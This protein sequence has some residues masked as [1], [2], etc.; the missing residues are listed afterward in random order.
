MKL[1]SDKNIYSF[2]YPDSVNIG[3]EI[4]TLAAIHVLKLLGLN[5]S[6]Y[7]NRDHPILEKDEAVLIVNG[8]FSIN[9][10]TFPLSENITPIFSNIH[11]NSTSL[12][13]NKLLT[14]KAIAYLK[15]HSPVGC[16]DRHTENML[17]AIGIDTYFNYC[18][19]LT[20][21]RRTPE[22]AAI[23]DTIFIVDLDT[24]V[25]LPKIFKN[26]K[27][28][29][30]KH[31]LPIKFPHKV[32]MDIAESLLQLYKTRASL[33]V[34][35]RLHC[36][37]PCIAMGIPVVV[38]GDHRDKRLQLVEEFIPI[39]PYFSLDMRG[40]ISQMDKPLWKRF[41][42]LAYGLFKLAFYRV[43]YFFYYRN[44]SWPTTAVDVEKI[45][46]KIVTNMRTA[47]TRL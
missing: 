18:L 5:I 31:N 7:L 16:R 30:V 38:M 46:E 13:P 22:E 41:L 29:Y 35:S 6:G 45:K 28:E 11:I 9:Q 4:Q 24:F 32:K 47:L 1:L 19:T 15:E 21:D 37:L 44:I 40:E 10:E 25:P 42:L 14:K 8:W 39:H 27:I 20:F 26:K 2:K 34:T 3:D 12:T 43:R 23:A 17:N 33:V 36:A